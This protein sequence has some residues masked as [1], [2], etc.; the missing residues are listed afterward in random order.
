VELA[1]AQKTPAEHGEMMKQDSQGFWELFPVCLLM[2]D[3]YEL[4]FLKRATEHQV[5]LSMVLS[6]VMNMELSMMPTPLPL[7]LGVVQRRIHNSMSFASDCSSPHSLGQFYN[8]CRC[9]IC[10]I[11]TETLDDVLAYLQSNQTSCL[12]G[13]DNIM[14]GNVRVTSSTLKLLFSRVSTRLCI[15]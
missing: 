5:V 13:K 6:M 7:P 3:D 8:C 14:R 4:V 11:P 2:P 10:N 15:R 1:L 9:R 12:K